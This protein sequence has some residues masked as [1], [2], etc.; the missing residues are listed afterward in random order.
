MRIVIDMQGAQTESRYRGIGRYTLAFTHAVVRHRGAHEVIL[1]LNGLFT[2]TLIPI[3]QAF[4]GLLPAENIKVWSALGPVYEQNPSNHP[5]RQVA[6]TIREAF[7]A[8]LQPDIVHLTSLLEGYVD[9]AVTSIR[10]FDQDVVCSV[11]LYDLIPL[12]NP[13]QYLKPNPSY[14]RYYRNK[15]EH[16][17]QA[18]CFLAISEFSRQEAIDTL[19]LAPKRVLNVGTSADAHFVPQSIPEAVARALLESYGITQPFVLYTGGADNRKNLP[20]LIQAYAGLPSTLR[21][22]HQLLLAG[23]MPADTIAQLQAIA[24]NAGL[25]EDELRFTN[26]VSDTTLVKLY[27]LCQLFVFPSWHE[28]FGLPALEAMSCGAPV[29]GANTSSLPEVIGLDEALFN[30]LDVEDITDSM[31]RALQDESLRARLRAHGLKQA[32]QFSWDHTGK[33]AIAAW[34][35]LHQSKAT[36]TA[37]R[38]SDTDVS[39]DLRPT[40]AFVSP[41]PPER[42]GIGFYSAELLPALAAHY[43]L[44]IV[45]AQAEVDVSWVQS[46]GP[47]RDIAWLRANAQNLDR[48]LYQ[49]GN[50][51]FH[52]HMLSL[53][54]EIPGVV[55]LHDFYLSDL[56]C[57]MESA[58]AP[59]TWKQALY[60]SHGYHAVQASVHNAREAK[61]HYPANAP[62]LQNATGVIVHSEHAREQATRWYGPAWGA[63]WDMVPLLREPAPTLNKA[64]LR[65]QHGYKQDDFVVCSFGFVAPTK[66]NHRLLEVWLSSALAPD[67]HCHLILVGENEGGDYGAQLLRTIKGSPHGQR[68]HITGFAT[69][70]LFTQYLALADAAVQ[71]R[72]QSRGETSA[73][74]LDCMNHGLPVI[75]N[76]HGS[77][78]ELPN[79]TVWMLPD[80]FDDH[81]LRSALEQLWR[82]PEQRSV[83][84]D[85]AREHIQKH[86]GPEPCALQYAHAIETAHARSAY[87]LQG[88][89]EALARQK[90]FAPS[91]AELLALAAQLARNHPQPRPAKRLYLDITATHRNDLKTGIERVVRAFLMALL[92]APP[93]GYRVEPV[94]LQSH[95]GAW[96]YCYARRYTLQL[97]NCPVDALA[98]EPVSPEPGDLLLGM[99]LSGDMLVQAAQAGLL[100]DYQ[101]QG[102]QVYWMVYDLLPIRLPEVFPPDAQR[103]HTQWLKAVTQGNG[104][105][106]ISQAVADDL[107]QWQREHEPPGT[108]GQRPFAVH[109]VHLGA[110]IDQTAPTTGLAADAQTL[111]D[112]FRAKPTFLMVGTIEPR[113]GYLQTLQAFEALWN[114]GVDVQL[115]IV[116][117]EGW[118]G[119][120]DSLR[121]DIPQTIQ[122]LQTHPER[123]QRL[124]WLDGI[125]DEQL[126]QTYAA[127]TC[128]IAASYGE[129][130]GLPLI[131][132]AQHQLP[133]IARDIPVFREVAG[134][135]SHYFPN[136][137]ALDLAN[138]IEAWLQLHDQGLHPTSTEMQWLTWQESAHQLIQKLPL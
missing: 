79:D 28:G 70:E 128:L 84:G 113:K 126:Q 47:V 95:Q 37:Q 88:L 93:Q 6:E 110:D 61:L 131:E 118:R 56:L 101:Q 109:A 60:A 36:T 103:Q 38:T 94:Y 8:S 80:T 73:T 124:F 89:L 12:L 26:Y 31:A 111:L 3:R 18:E 24:R 81:A 117:R 1:A 21:Q 51:P 41:L 30:P 86:H 120:P 14:E 43:R 97:L 122:A 16:L 27:N 112:Q 77:M 102:M 108:A 91:E 132:A 35:A 5:R 130:F 78:A 17:R 45:V 72:A 134:D 92:V 69:Q 138:A 107:R 29:I 52:H 98:D 10:V 96:H 22:S 90:N 137:N 2:E 7:I 116:G 19:S 121:R 55:V 63:D 54:E 64:A 83:L 33:Q 106:C 4:D 42:T 40:L 13:E 123:G 76:A 129:G 119:L 39:Q 75:V 50:S 135:H 34:E 58:G 25:R 59:N 53:L 100:Q 20:R 136:G 66:L 85:K 11:S 44:E 99:D 125:S 133:I 114:R 46:N 127:C 23:K 62:L 87:G 15:I 32:Q 68:V 105:I 115:A 74:V 67:P 104:A 65:A 82:S 9:D 71:L 48:V 49:M 57:W